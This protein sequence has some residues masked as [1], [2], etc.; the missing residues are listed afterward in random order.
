MPIICQSADDLPVY[1]VIMM[2]VVAY[3][4][5]FS[6]NMFFFLVLIAG[7]YI[8]Y[9]FAVSIKVASIYP[10]IFFDIS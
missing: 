9:N 8:L 7:A 5:D 1:S 3:P 6:I 10:G 2:C 4:L